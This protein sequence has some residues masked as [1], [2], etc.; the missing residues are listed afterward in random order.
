MT[1][2]PQQ[3]LIELKR[4]GLINDHATLDSQSSD[5]TPWY[6][7]VFFGL[8]G[9]LASV[10]FLA[11][12][13][14]ILVETNILDSTAGIFIVGALLSAAG[15]F[16]FHHE[17]IRQS[18]F[19]HGLA[20][21]ISGAGQVY[22]AIALFMEGIVP[23]SLW[24]FLL[25]KTL[26]T[27]LMPNFVYRLLSSAI[28]LGCIVYLLSYY[29]I[30]E[31][32]LGLLALVV[33]VANLQ[34]Y[35]LLQRV[36]HKARL[37]AFDISKAVAH[38]SALVLLGVSVYFIVSEGTYAVA[39][40]NEGFHYNYYLAQGLLTLA[41]LYAAYLILRRYHFK[42][43]SVAGLII[44]SALAVL[45]VMS[46]YVSGLLATSLV[47]VI[48]MANSQRLLLGAGVFALVGYVFWYYYQLD[49]SLL[50]KSI[51]M[52]IIGIGLLLMRWLL[53]GRYFA[54][55]RHSEGLYHD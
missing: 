22:I 3:A 25:I 19:W 4:I 50:T 12:L 13:T 14:L 52:L 34:R 49:T 16:M 35:S 26:L 43:L 38:S 44:V 47:I 48:A 36:P 51:S 6:L 7:Q 17:H 23:I 29:G 11:F 55:H 24:L 2:D 41:S 15:G 40:Y 37:A 5:H 8:S 20:F 39:T 46:I 27:I 54:N 21:A 1:D 32:S 28:A 9:V 10:L 31:F 33:I 18:P 53:I 45:G 42:T 30:P